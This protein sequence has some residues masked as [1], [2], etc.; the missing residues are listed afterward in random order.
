MQAYKYALYFLGGTA[1]YAFLWC[2]FKMKKG[3]FKPEP[4]EQALKE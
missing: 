1:I 3:L 4:Y 2:K